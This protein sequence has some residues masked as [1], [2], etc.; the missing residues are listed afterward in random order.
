MSNALHTGQ[1][2]RY[3][4][5]KVTGDTDKPL[6]MLCEQLGIRLTKDEAKPDTG[7]SGQIGTVR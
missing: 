6:S 2:L 3:V 1:E 4:V 7:Q 5:K